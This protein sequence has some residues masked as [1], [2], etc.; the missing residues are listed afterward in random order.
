MKELARSNNVV[1]LSWLTALLRSE[2]IECVVLDGHTSVLEG[3]IS[4]ITRRVMVEES[5]HA[6]A[7]RLMEAA[8]AEI[9]RGDE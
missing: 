2:G 3:S 8:T 9:E 1:F 4:A 5:D 6:R 7:G